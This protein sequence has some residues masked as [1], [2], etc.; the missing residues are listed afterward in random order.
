MG[1]LPNIARQAALLLGA[2]VAEREHGRDA[3]GFEERPGCCKPGAPLA[4][5]GPRRGLFWGGLELS[6]SHVTPKGDDKGGE[7]NGYHW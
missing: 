3:F 1:E 2:L 7:E 4:L 5:P 6:Q